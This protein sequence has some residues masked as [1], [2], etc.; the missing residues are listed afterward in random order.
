MTARM[1]RSSHA[2]LGTRQKLIPTVAAM[3]VT[4]G[5]T[6]VP[7]L[8]GYSLQ[9]PQGENVAS[10]AGTGSQSLSVAGGGPGTVQRDKF[11]VSSAPTIP[12]ASRKSAFAFTSGTFIN[13]PNSPIQW[14]FVVG[15]PI[16]TGFGPRVAPCWGC[17][18]FHDGLDMTPGGGTPVQA[19]MGG[20]VREVSA[21]DKGELGVYAIIDHRVNGQLVSSLYAHMLQGSL[22]LHP[23]Q[24]V[25]VGQQVGNVGNTGLST[26]A[27][28]HLGILLNGVSPTNPFTWLMAHVI[29]G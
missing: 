9:A 15:V 25:R 22:T 11:T 23:G 1:P 16:S 27:H 26:G 21:T 18:G 13:N 19:I 3:I 4:L 10:G 5:L 17:S 7:A 20:V 28:L 14:P 12:R 6:A 24:Q 29:P 2:S 8:P